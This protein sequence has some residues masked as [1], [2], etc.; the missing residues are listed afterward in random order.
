MSPGPAPLLRA[1]EPRT[2]PLE[3]LLHA[4]GPV[5]DLGHGDILGHPTT[6]I[7]S[8]RETHQA[9][10]TGAAGVL[11]ETA[12]VDVRRPPRVVRKGRLPDDQEGPF[13][14]RHG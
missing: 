3:H 13:P 12:A 5:L 8:A 11:D 7:A 14:A 2:N 6:V 9:I 10:R 1:S 4:H